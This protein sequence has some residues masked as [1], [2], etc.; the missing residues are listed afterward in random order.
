MK[1]E[2]AAEF[3]SVLCDGELI[4][5]PAA[6]HI[7]GCEAC[8]ARLAEYAQMGAELR[9]AA[10]LE[11]E[12]AAR[13][14]NSEISER[15]SASWWQKGWET[16]RIPRLVFALLTVA[17]VVLGS[18]LA[19]VSARTHPDGT[20]LM[21]TATPSDTGP[22]RCALSLTDEKSNQCGIT[23]PGGES[24]PVRVLSEENGRIKLGIR[25]GLL[26]GTKNPDGSVTYWVKGFQSMEEKQY[27]FV[28]GQKLMAPIPELGNLVITGELMDHI[29]TL[30]DNNPGE[31]VD[32]KADE[33]RFVRPIL[34]QG[35]QVILDL[36][37]ST[38]IAPDKNHC[39]EVYVPGQGLFEIS[40]L[41]QQGAVEGRISMSRV[42]F[43]LEGQSYQFVLAAPV[44]RGEEVWILRDQSYEPPED[45]GK[46][47]FLGTVELGKE[48]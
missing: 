3:V 43:E 40:L 1:C 38:E 10:S 5:Q 16:M 34:L 23:G 8:P 33:L 24:Y 39:I 35:K 6:E 36:E 14:R 11:P 12:S 4:P 20:V 31:Q 7:R 27:W 25:G 37:D 22:F 46:G 28:P 13:E 26:A 2:E 9:C 15:T 32:P 48:P 41:P 47:G 18:G 17:I 30:I 19:I 42:S 44:A 21:M 29:P 45:F